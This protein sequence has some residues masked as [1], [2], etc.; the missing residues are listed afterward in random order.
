MTKKEQI[1]QLLDTLKNCLV[2]HP[3]HDG[4]HESKYFTREDI[5]IEIS[6]QKSKYQR[7]FGFG[8]PHC[9]A[10]L[11]FNLPEIISVAY[12]DS[13]KRPIE[14]KIV[15]ICKFEFIHWVK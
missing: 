3:T 14:I 8:G 1:K 13:R 11:D 15:E 4:Q 5:A 10:V 9:S 6:V 7:H 12:L 2:P